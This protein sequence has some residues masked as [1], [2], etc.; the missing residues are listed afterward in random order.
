[1]EEKKIR[2]MI[3]KD[4][5]SNCNIDDILDEISMNEE[6]LDKK[7]SEVGNSYSLGQYEVVEY[8][9]WVIVFSEETFEAK[10]LI[11]VYE[12][13]GYE[14]VEEKELL[15]VY[16]REEIVLYFSDGTTKKIATR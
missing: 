5:Y 14:I 7:P 13:Y 2:D 15:I 1:M 9:E 16:G 12:L 11:S 4:I 10:A 8:R 3:T 6:F